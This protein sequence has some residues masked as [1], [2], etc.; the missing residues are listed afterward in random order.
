MR[1]ALLT[2]VCLFFMV[3]QS[4]ASSYNYISPEDM[5]ADLESAN[6]YIIADIQVEDAFAEHHLPGSV[7]TYAYPVKSD[8]ERK[9]LDTIVAQQKADD[10][11]VVIVC[12][13]GG[14]GA[15]RAYDYLKESGVSEENL[16]I[17]TKGMDGWPYAELV[18]KTK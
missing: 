3:S 12:P 5:K 8:A 11:K 6:S 1:T 18:E 4:Y 9:Q 16:L 7:G 17:L 14:G 13:R 2:L 10:K 15:K